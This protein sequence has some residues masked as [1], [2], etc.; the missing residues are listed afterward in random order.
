MIR[1]YKSKSVRL[2][3]IGWTII[4][5]I[6]IFLLGSHCWRKDFGSDRSIRS[7]VIR[8]HFSFDL[9]HKSYVSHMLGAF[10]DIISMAAYTYIQNC[11]LAFFIGI[12]QI[13][14]A[15]FT[16]SISDSFPKSIRNIQHQHIPHL[17]RLL[18]EFRVNYFWAN[19]L[20]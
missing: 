10:F 18:R 16:H 2:V 13:N 11:Y 1:S 5:S 12:I 6:R 7:W 20:V 9:G 17:G 8:N 3:A 14:D 4:P 15:F 19:A